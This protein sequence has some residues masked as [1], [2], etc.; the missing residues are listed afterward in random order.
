MVRTADRFL[1]VGNSGMYRTL[2]AVVGGE[3]LAVRTGNLVHS[4]RLGDTICDRR[5]QTPSDRKHQRP[6]EEKA[7]WYQ[8]RLNGMNQGVK[9]FKHGNVL[10]IADENT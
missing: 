7:N 1:S 6:G 9:Q 8:E 4:L 10:L 5:P 3:K 2:E